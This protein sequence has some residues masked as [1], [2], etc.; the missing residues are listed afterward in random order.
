M[1]FDAIVENPPYQKKVG[2]RKTVPLWDAFLEKSVEYL[3]PDGYLC[4]VHP[5]G[6][7]NLGGHTKSAG[8]LIK[9]RDVQYLEMHSNLDALKV[10]GVSIHYDWYILRNRPNQGP[11]EV[12]FQDGTKKTL[13]IKDLSF[14]PNAEYDRVIGLLAK[15]GEP[16]CEIL[17]NSVYGHAKPHMS[18]K[19]TK[20]FCYPIINYIKADKSLS[21]YYSR[22]NDGHFGVPKVIYTT[23]HVGIDAIQT[24]VD[25]NG[26]YGLT[27][28][29][30][31]IVDSKENLPMIEKCINSAEFKKFAKNIVFGDN[32]IQ[33][34][35]LSL[36]RKDFWKEFI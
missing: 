18:K 9:S 26:D 15:E 12:K 11:T 14:I 27:E 31:G 1:I 25:A 21:L 20:R 5:S 34:R 13:N 33:H 28:F 6:W 2:K 16:T 22:T 30:V 10:F 8:N 4:I 17:R 35:V 19:K 24:L 3:K 29:A 32:N 23:S 7:R 36:F